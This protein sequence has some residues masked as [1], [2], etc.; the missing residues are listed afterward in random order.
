MLYNKPEKYLKKGKPCKSCK[1]NS[2]DHLINQ[3]MNIADGMNEYAMDNN[4]N[5]SQL[6]MEQS[7]FS[8]SQFLLPNSHFNAQDST[9]HSFHQ[10]KIN[11][12]TRQLFNNSSSIVNQNVAPINNTAMLNQN[13]A[14]INNT[15]ML[16]QNITPI[17]NTAMLNQNIAPINNTTMLNQNTAPINPLTKPDENSENQFWAKMILLVKSSVKSKLDEFSKKIDTI[18]TEKVEENMKPLKDKVELLEAEMVQKD[19][20]IKIR[21]SI[22]INQQ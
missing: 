11:Q 1:E 9:V 2:V 8:G 7:M 5:C 13:I 12:N 15:T 17:N 20:R 16:N 22:V 6:M 19:D 21:T 3:D 10:P 4:D 14:P 18:I